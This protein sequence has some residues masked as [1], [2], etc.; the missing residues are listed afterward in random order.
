M[1]HAD[2]YVRQGSGESGACMQKEGW[3]LEVVIGDPDSW[4]LRRGSQAHRGDPQGAGRS[5]EESSHYLPLPHYTGHD[6]AQ[7]SLS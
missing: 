2:V 5:S 3:A 1:A 4:G 6:P 7:R